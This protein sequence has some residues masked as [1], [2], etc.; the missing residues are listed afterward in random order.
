[1]S[2]KIGKML[3]DCMQEVLSK[4]AGLLFFFDISLFSLVSI[5]FES[6]LCANTCCID[7]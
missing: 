6:D 4:S 5:V 3:G 1:M 7:L 2:N